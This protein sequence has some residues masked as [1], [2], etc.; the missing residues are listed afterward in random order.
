MS[1]RSIKNKKLNMPLFGE[2]SRSSLDSF[3]SNGKVDQIQGRSA[4]FVQKWRFQSFVFFPT[5]NRPKEA[6]NWNA[7]FE[8]IKPIVLGFMRIGRE[9][10]PNPRTIGLIRSEVAFSNLSVS[11]SEL[12]RPGVI[13]QISTT[14]LQKRCCGSGGLNF[15]P[16]ATTQGSCNSRSRQ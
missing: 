8:R 7:T 14:N 11:S 6:K 9:S 10:G 2:L 3:E 4:S 12:A 5:S 16:P 15:D 1:N 13:L